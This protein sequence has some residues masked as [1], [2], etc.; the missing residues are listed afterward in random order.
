MDRSESPPPT[1]REMIDAFVHAP[2]LIPIGERIDG[3]GL[4]VVVGHVEVW[5]WRVVVRA[6]VANP[7][8][9][10]RPMRFPTASGDASAELGVVTV[11]I[12]DLNEQR[13]ER[14]RRNREWMNSWTLADDTG[15]VFP[16]SGWSGSPSDDELW[17][18]L[19]LTY[20]MVVPP[21]AQQLIISGPTIGQIE[22]AVPE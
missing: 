5:R 2:T 14:L 11:E 20:D 12:G 21:T 7:D 18:D 22:V 9:T 19:A 15:T 4:V 6:L 17:C 16:P 13:L 10:P 8:F 1:A 3:D